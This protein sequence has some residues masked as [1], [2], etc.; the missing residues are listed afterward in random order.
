VIR[1]SGFHCIAVNEEINSM[2]FYELLMVMKRTN[3]KETEIN[4]F[5]QTIRGNANAGFDFYVDHVRSNEMFGGH[6]LR[7]FY[8]RL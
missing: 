1:L 8:S 2:K 3:F 6:F 4:I 5:L 7:K